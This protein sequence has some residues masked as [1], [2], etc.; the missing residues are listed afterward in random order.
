MNSQLLKVLQ[1][2]ICAGAISEKADGAL[3]CLSCQREY[4]TEKDILLLYPDKFDQSHLAEEIKLS[5]EMKKI[6]ETEREKISREQWEL[7]K[8]EFWA[9]VKKE[10]GQ[11]TEGLINIGCGYD[12]NFKYFQDKNY[13]FVNFDLVPNILEN[14]KNKGAENCVAGDINHLPFS[15]NS[16]DNLI[17]IDVIHHESERLEKILGSFAKILK[18]GGKIF[19]EDVNAWG[20]FQFHKS[21]FMPRFLHRFLRSVYHQLKKTAH[22]PADY[23]FPTNPFKVKRILEKIGFTDIKF[24]SFDSYPEKSG[25]PLTVYRILKGVP[26]V[27]TYHNFHYF[28]SAKKK[29]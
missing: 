27:R 2:P 11:S 7:S 9:I 17:C 16:F 8:Q 14:L 25:L 19:L 4:K 24:Y 29:K 6:D 28:V 18:P 22:Q 15:E 12:E 26:L 21:I 10:I 3:I 5:E 13:F 1:C 20:L 23:E